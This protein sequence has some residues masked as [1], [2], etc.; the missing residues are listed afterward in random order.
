MAFG[1]MQFGQFKKIT[2]KVFEFSSVPT[3][4]ICTKDFGIFK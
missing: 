3:L 2:Q 4:K 1:F